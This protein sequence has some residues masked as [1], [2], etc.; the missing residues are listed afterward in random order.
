MI[1]AIAIIAIISLGTIGLL[2]VLKGVAR[3]AS[4]KAKKAVIDTSIT[5]GL[6][7]GISESIINPIGMRL[8]KLIKIRKIR[9]DI[10]S[11]MLNRLRINGTPEEYIGEFIAKSM[12]ISCASIV[13]IPFGM[14][15][16]T[17]LLIAYAILYSI[18]GVVDLDEKIEALN[19]QL[20]NELPY[21]LSFLKN[22]LKTKLSIVD[23]LKDYRIISSKRMRTEID[24]VLFKIDAGE[25]PLLVL[26]DLDMRLR[27][28]IYT[29]FIGILANIHEGIP[30]NNAMDNLKEVL[31]IRK[32]EK[33]RKE[34]LA[35]PDKGNGPMA[36]LLFAFVLFL[37]VGIFI[38]IQNG[39]GVIF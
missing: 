22:N 32:A 31:K 21:M 16:A 3:I 26:T 33:L 36:M 35:G 12:L 13:F 17:L 11:A 20:E 4:N 7:E 25:Q 8:S 15:W 5:P 27:I 18:K 6:N 28:P 14:W 30:C 29:Q 38:S 19:N 34:T 23:F 37:F 10:M 24:W 1:V 39:L 9:R 2:F